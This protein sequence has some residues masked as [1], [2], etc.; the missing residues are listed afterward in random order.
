M[1]DPGMLLAI[2]DVLAFLAICHVIGTAI[3]LAVR[4]N[5]RGIVPPS[6]LIGC[7]ALGVQ[8]WAFG[9]AHIPWNVFTLMLPWVA[10]WVVLRR[11][12]RQTLQRQ[13]NSVW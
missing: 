4:V 1:P 10:V 2:V 5:V 7:A 12:L 13:I 8:L 11:S 3:L 6:A 9:F